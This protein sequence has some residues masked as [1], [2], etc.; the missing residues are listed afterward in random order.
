MS[1]NYRLLMVTWNADGVNSR[2]LE[3]R[4]F[5]NKY[6]PEIISLQE[7][8]LRPSHTL[9]LANY[10]TY[11]NDRKHNPHRNQSYRGGGTAILIKNTIKHTRIPTPN[12]VNAEATMVAITPDRGDATLITSLYV[13]GTSTTATITSNI[14]TILNLGFPS[15]I[16][17]GD[18][19]AKHSAWGCENECGRGKKLKSYT[20]QKG[21][22][23]R[24]S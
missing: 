14:E 21:L 1:P 13:H 3:L 5:I 2:R 11:R 17:M 15:C 23:A 10:R 4:D 6:N 19:N 24:E 18:F 7:T 12:L 22:R 16:I 8:W 20:E 9:T